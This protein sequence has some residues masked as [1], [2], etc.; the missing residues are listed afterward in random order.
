ML[1]NRLRR[2][3]PIQDIHKCDANSVRFCVAYRDKQIVADTVAAM[4]AETRLELEKESGFPLLVSRYKKRVGL[5][6]GATVGVFLIYFS[7][8]FIWDIRVEGNT[9]VEDA[10]ILKTLQTLGIAEGKPKETKTLE[11]IYNS[12]LLAEPR[13]SW[14]SVN[15]DGT[16]AHVEVKEREQVP[17][18]RDRTKNINIV[19]RC[20]GVIHRVDALDGSSEVTAGETVTKGQLLISSFVQTRKTGTI[21]QAARGSVWASTVRCYDIYVPRSEQ[22]KQY[23]GNTSIRRSIRILGR[24]L[25]LNIPYAPSYRNYVKKT[26]TQPC[27]LLENVRLPFYITTETLREYRTEEFLLDRE[28]AS[29]YAAQELSLRMDAE[30]ER[31]EILKREENVSQTNDAYIFHYELT[32]LENIAQEVEFEFAP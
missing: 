12:F 6:I 18:K 11:K 20:D 24:E 14:L 3:I 22:I 21:M 23:T 15:Y 29:E 9:Y 28:T 5:Y 4:G 16:V 10:D 17:E 8:L 27:I 19:A 7:S 13:I 32:C 30:L 25:P 26:V 31:A 1:I 2:R